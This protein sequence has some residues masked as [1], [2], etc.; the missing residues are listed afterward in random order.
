MPWKETCPMDQKIQLI[1]AWLTGRYSKVELSRRFCVSRKTVHKYL[2]RY[3]LLGEAGLSECSRAPHCHPNAVSKEVIHQVLS[4][5]RRYPHWGP[6]KIRD[7]L[8]LNHGDQDWP[9]A[10]TLGSILKR[11]GHVKPRKSR[12]GRVPSSD[13]LSHCI[14]PN[15]VWSADFKGHFRMGNQRWC[16]PL[17]VSDNASRYLL[18]C[19]GMHRPTEQ[20][21]WAPF[22]RVFR[23]YGLPIAM[24]TDNGSPFASTALGGLTRLN[25]WFIKLGIT[26]ERIAPGQPQQN[27]RHERMHRTLKA[28]APPQGNLSAQQRA[29]N[30]FR[31][32]YNEERP[33]ESLQGIPPGRIYQSSNRHYPHKLPLV[34]YDT[35]LTVR[36]VRSNG[37]IK[38]RGDLIYLSEALRN[39]SVGLRQIDEYRWQVYFAH[40]PL[41]ILDEIRC[42]IERPNR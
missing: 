29:F 9:A 23:E 19:R 37:E 15:D 7:Y 35:C 14:N 11:Y 33:H 41:G 24:R 2:D 31:H 28:E 22:E 27:G 40:Y 26:P 34:E 30:R 17:T 36:H 4:I 32:E 13:P 25:V 1:A 6:V 8:R 5:K 16:Y 18:E 21:V 39:E 42:K 3:S 20:G 12:S 10:S 38:W